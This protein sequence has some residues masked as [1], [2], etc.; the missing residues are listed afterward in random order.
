MEKLVCSAAEFTNTLEEMV[1]SGAGV[2]LY[3]SGSSMTPFLLDGRDIVWLRRCTKADLKRGQILLFKR[4]DE[5]LVLHRVKKVLP[6]GRLL[7]NGDAQNWCETV[8]ESSVIAAVY[9]LERDGKKR[10]C[11]SPFLTVRNFFWQLLMPLR[12]YIMRLW[13]KMNSGNLE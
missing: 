2:P 12:P 5:S 3:V 7:M 6:D 8:Q 4:S 10:Q 13:R 11:S 9:G 1:Q